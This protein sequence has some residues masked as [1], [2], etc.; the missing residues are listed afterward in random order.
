MNPPRNW[1]CLV[2]GFVFAGIGLS[3]C[4]NASMKNPLTIALLTDYGTK[5]A[6]V[7]E[8]K[9]ALLTVNNRVRL[10]DLT[11]EIEAFNIREAAYL[12]D[13]S[14]REFPSGT[15]FIGV[16]DPGVGTKRNPLLLKTKSGK[17][18]IG[19]DNGLFTLVAE[20]EGLEGAWDLNNPE[21]Y[22]KGVVSAT[23]HGRDI[24]GPVAGH[25]AAGISPGKLGAKLPDIE[26]IPYN[27]PLSSSK[28]ITGDIL[29]I[30]HYGNII[31]NIPAGF[32]PLLKESNLLRLTVGSQTVSAPLVRT[33]GDVAASRMLLVYNSQGLLE[34]AVN[35]GSAKA[36]LKAKVGDSV[37]LKQ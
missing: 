7:A 35:K 37:T 31:T 29:H 23:F 6:Y 36:V 34:I 2:A 25:L 18:Y 15:I 13:Q 27:A 8:L 16:V 33:Y 24:F 20:R 3:G 19:P 28:S 10:L 5:D 14:S 4:G 11:H 9:G 26:K 30:D 12:L 21:Y 1:I 22:R 17:F 32:S